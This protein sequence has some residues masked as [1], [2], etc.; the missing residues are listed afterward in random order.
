MAGGARGKGG[1][2]DEKPHDR[3]MNLRA[4]THIKAPR[5]TQ[6]I[7]TV[8]TVTFHDVMSPTHRSAPT[9]YPIP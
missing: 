2:S 7:P 5:L 3:H 8:H 4:L 9:S 6:P 1:S